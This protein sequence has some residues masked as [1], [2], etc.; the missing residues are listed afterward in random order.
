M[1]R[2]NQ[3][4][5]RFYEAEPPGR[6]NLIT[7]SWRHARQAMIRLRNDLRIDDTVHALHWTWMGDLSNKRVLDLGCYAGNP[8]SLDIAERAHA[9]LGVDL[10]E[11]AIAQLRA[12]LRARGLDHAEARAV[13]FL[14]GE[15]EGAPFDVIYAYSVMH[16]FKYFDAFL[17]L[18]AG[19]LAPGGVVIS[20]DPLQTSLAVRL[21]RALYRPFQSDRAWEWPFSRQSF[22]QIQQHFRIEALQ[23][24]LG[25]AK[26]AFPPALLNYSL[27]LRLG[28]WLHA[29]DL[30]TAD[31]LGRGLWRCMHVTMCL[32]QRA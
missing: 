24:T 7:R 11:S 3:R 1:L 27:G 30:R 2:I 5:K 20:I 10:S 9:Y 29:R 15:V 25:Y 12:L 17:S 8:L 13:D 4:Q 16:H 18:L 6:G 19:H 23:G 14:S 32:K 26:W 31:R 21:A 22:A 28:R